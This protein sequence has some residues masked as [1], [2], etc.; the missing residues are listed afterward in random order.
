VLTYK[1]RAE[2]SD[3]NLELA[4]ASLVESLTIAGDLKDPVATEFGPKLEAAGVSSMWL[5]SRARVKCHIGAMARQTAVSRPRYRELAMM[6]MEAQRA[7]PSALSKTAGMHVLVV[8][9][10][11][12]AAL[13]Q[14]GPRG[15]Q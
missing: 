1:G 11:P 7:I 12:S 14:L 2:F 5:P 8:D 10:D 6:L 13:R 4:E 15:E 9:D 3:G